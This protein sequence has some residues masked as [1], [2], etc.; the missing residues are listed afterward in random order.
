MDG[1]ILR[2]IRI[3]TQRE[4]ITIYHDAYTMLPMHHCKDRHNDR[5]DGTQFAHCA[6]T[7]NERPIRNLSSPQELNVAPVPLVW[8]V[9]HQPSSRWNHRVRTITQFLSFE[10]SVPWVRS[11]Y[12]RIYFPMCS[13]L[14]IVTTTW[15]SLTHTQS[16]NSFKTNEMKRLQFNYNELSTKIEEIVDLMSRAGLAIATVKETKLLQENNSSELYRFHRNTLR[17]WAKWWLGPT[18][19][20]N[21]TV[22]YHLIDGGIDRRDI[23]LER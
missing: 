7:P 13:A 18:F 8:L 5:V 22:L 15:T 12:F 11:Q 19:I 17:W 1:V 16:H 6:T 9:P 21:N 2:L 14:H 20:L 23:I 10:M 3:K 4:W